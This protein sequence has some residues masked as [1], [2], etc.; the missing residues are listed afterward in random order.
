ML[1]FTDKNR[2]VFAK[3]VSTNDFGSDVGA[4]G[5]WLGAFDNAEEF[6]GDKEGLSVLGLGG[7]VVRGQGRKGQSTEDELVE[8]GD[9]LIG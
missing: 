5:I 9:C 8:V 2:A 1:Q 7:I 3:E 6:V 4:S